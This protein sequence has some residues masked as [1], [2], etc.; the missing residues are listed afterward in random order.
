VGTFGKKLLEP[1]K[2]LRDRVRSG[3]SAAIEAERSCLAR[4][5]GPQ[6]NRIGQKSRS[7]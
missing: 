1:T 2:R 7:T 3:H 6:L 4:D 5:L